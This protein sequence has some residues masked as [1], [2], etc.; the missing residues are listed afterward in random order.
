MTA[1]GEEIICSSGPIGTTLETTPIPRL[2]VGSVEAKV[3][4]SLQ[5]LRPLRTNLTI[6]SS[7]GA[8]Q[9]P[10]SDTDSCQQMWHREGQEEIE[11]NLLR[12]HMDS[13]QRPA[14]LIAKMSMASALTQ[15]RVRLH[16][17]LLAGLTLLAF[18]KP[19]SLEIR[20]SILQ[21]KYCSSPIKLNKSSKWTRFK[22]LLT[23]VRKAAGILFT[24]SSTFLKAKSPSFYAGLSS[25]PNNISVLILEPMRT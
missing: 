24:C 4:V 1:C 13:A 5:G 12:L 10:E 17:S 21:L 14:R 16:P 25:K 9:E 3:E 8:F 18:R 23:Q 22:F 15:G 20:T 6:L 19:S 2:S 11:H 7:G